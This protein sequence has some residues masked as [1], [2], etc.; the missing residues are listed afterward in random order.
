[1]SASHVRDGAER[2]A[3]SLDAEEEAALADTIE[4][5]ATAND[6]PAL[7][8]ALDDLGWGDALLAAPSVAASAL[9]G[10][11]GAACTTSTALSRVV[12]TT[13]GIDDATRRGAPFLLPAFGGAAPTAGSASDDGT[14]HLHGLVL[15]GPP[16]LDASAVIVVDGENRWSRVELSALGSSAVRPAHGLDPS[17]GLVVIDGRLDPATAGGLTW[18]DS[19]ASWTDSTWTDAVAIA[20]LAVGHELVGT[21]RTMVELARTHA[22]ERIQFGR[23]IAGFQAVRHRL[24]ESLVATEAASAALDGAWTDGSDEA[25]ALAKAACGQS[26]KVVRR[27]CQQVLAGIGFTAEHEF[28]R[29]LRRS[30]VLDGLFT[31][32]A[33]LIDD[34]GR[35]AINARALPSLLPL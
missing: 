19:D 14:L 6:G 33:T 13:L 32:S 29:F 30:I 7:D 35:Q 20:R 23:P 26:A 9:F 17:L 28:H 4:R 3:S 31:G 15:G 25:A 11:Q 5:V 21:M 12:A 10:A 16:A 2:W 18:T 34:I 1:M 27:H 24:A 8:R 22:L